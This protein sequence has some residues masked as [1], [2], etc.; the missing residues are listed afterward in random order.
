MHT[1]CCRSCGNTALPS[2]YKLWFQ[3]YGFAGE[4]ESLKGFAGYSTSGY[5]FALGGD[6]QFWNARMVAG[7][8]YGYSNNFLETEDWT[9][10][11]A[12]TTDPSKV[13][14]DVHTLL[15]YAMLRGHG[16]FASVKMGGSWGIVS[17]DRK[18]TSDGYASYATDAT[19]YLMQVTA[20][21]SFIENYW[22]KVTPKLRFSYFNYA[23]DAYRET[24]IVSG[25]AFAM[26][27]EKYGDGHCEFELLI[28]SKLRIN[29]WAKGLVTVGYRKMIDADGAVLRV[30]SDGL[31]Y[32]V[33]GIAA[34]QDVF[35]MDLGG[36]VL[37]SEQLSFRVE[38]NLRSAQ[39][40]SLH[41]GTGTL[42][43]V[44]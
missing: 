4:Q 36:E 14:T 3:S 21:Y 6:Q 28:D 40:C 17:G 5:G 39:K 42:S 30:H 33:N 37:I 29:N 44:F 35:L 1:D 24:G 32:N 18:P 41:G 34:P 7:L 27:V 20:G 2:S 10:T 12:T 25:K 26:D 23:Q 11:M 38:Y 43:Y 9:T 16:I 19:T 8:A 15:G 22:L 31:S 13:T